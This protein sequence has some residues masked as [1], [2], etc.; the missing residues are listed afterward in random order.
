[1]QTIGC[2]QPYKGLSNVS[3]KRAS[4]GHLKLGLETIDEEYAAQ[5]DHIAKKIKCWS[6]ETDPT[7][8]NCVSAAAI[9]GWKRLIKPSLETELQIFC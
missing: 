2:S 5:I 1:M 8:M 6:A 7:S 3:F 9:D 4:E